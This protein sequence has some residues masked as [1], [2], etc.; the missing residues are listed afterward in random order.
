MKFFG[1]DKL[2][3]AELR[4]EEKSELSK[5]FC[6]ENFDFANIGVLPEVVL[7]I[8]EDVANQHAEKLGIGF[9][10][11]I[12]KH[13]LWVVMRIRYEVLI[14]PMA[15]VKYTITTYPSGKNYMEF[16]RDYII[17][18]EFGNAIIKGQSKWC[19]MDCIE[20]R[21]VKMIDCVTP[22]QLGEPL[23]EGR[24]LK[25]DAFEPKFLPDGRYRICDADIDSNRHTNNT[26]YAKLATELLKNESRNIKFFQI[27]FLKEC[28]LD[29]T[30]DLFLQQENENVYSVL[31]RFFDKKNSFNAT[32]EFEQK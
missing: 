3:N 8:F 26:V 7:K 27:N 11:M 17:T 13:L 24:F 25:T 2:Q 6:F 23:F 16:D 14:Q 32:I 28:F 9:L 20:R 15:N 10:S 31:G 1:N 22:E 19:V 5:T 4:A 12:S 21:L 18:D 30:L 29:D